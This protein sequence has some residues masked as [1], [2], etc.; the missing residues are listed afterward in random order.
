MAVRQSQLHLGDGGANPED[1]LGRPHSSHCT[2]LLGT[3]FVTS[4][5]ALRRELS[6]HKALGGH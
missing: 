6:H 4:A 2:E 5:P 1:G 3:A